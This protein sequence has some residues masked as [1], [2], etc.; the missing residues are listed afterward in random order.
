MP[1]RSPISQLSALNS[2]LRRPRRARGLMLGLTTALLAACAHGASPAPH[3]PI[4]L[5]PENPRYFF[6]RDK[7][8]ILIG[9]SVHHCAVVNA[10]FDYKTYLDTVAADRSNVTRL[11][12]GILVE[13]E[14]GGRRCPSRKGN[15][16]P[17]GSE[18]TPPDTR[19]AGTSLI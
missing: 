11:M 10:E 14:G 8:T 12:T 1:S 9:A 19:S 15:C 2:Q 5:H 16:C 7:T 3:D 13:K 6:W 17:L 18:V 4:R